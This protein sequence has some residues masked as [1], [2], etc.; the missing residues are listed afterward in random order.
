MTDAEI[1]NRKLIA[2]RLRC[3]ARNLEA[4]AAAVEL[5]A[6]D[7]VTQNFNDAHKQLEHAAFEYETMTVTTPTGKA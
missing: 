3:A 7:V 2:V 6:D 4:A 5:Q 1:Q